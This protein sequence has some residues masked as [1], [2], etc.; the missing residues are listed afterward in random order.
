M[1][2]KKKKLA[3]LTGTV[4]S[5]DSATGTEDEHIASEHLS[6]AESTLTRGNADIAT[7]PTSMLWLDTVPAAERDQWQ[8]IFSQKLQRHFYFHISSKT[9]Q[10]QVPAALAPFYEAFLAG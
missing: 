7:E 4:V 6:Q 2:A 8:I 10:F 3:A 9:G 5:E 1:K